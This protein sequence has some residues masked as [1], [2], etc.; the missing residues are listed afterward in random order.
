[1]FTYENGLFVSFLFYCYYL[2]TLFETINSLTEKNLNK[3]GERHSWITLK[4]KNM[5]KSDFDRPFLKSLGKFILVALCHGIFVF[6]SWI[7]VAINLF[8]LFNRLNADKG[9]PENVK[10]FRWKLRNQ[11]L[12]FDELIVEVIKLKGLSMDD[13]EDVKAELTQ[14]VNDRRVA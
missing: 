1:M 8:A 5:D 9:V 4:T 14:F 10:E 12:T 3:V 6:L 2:Y 7:N 11:D 13:F